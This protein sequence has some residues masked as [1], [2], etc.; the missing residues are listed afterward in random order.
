MPTF[1]KDLAATITDPYLS[2][3]QDLGEQ[4]VGKKCRLAMYSKDEYME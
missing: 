2:D 3:L 1:D 4:L